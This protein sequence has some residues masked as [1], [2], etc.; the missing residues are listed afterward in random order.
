MGYRRC[1]LETTGRMAQARTL[2]EKLGFAP[3]DVPFG[4]TG[5]SAC[6]SWY[7]KEL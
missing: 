4:R 3:L 7:V 6:D 1:Y 5:H 2:Y